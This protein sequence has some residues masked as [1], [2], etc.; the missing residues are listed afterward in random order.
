MGLAA[1]LVAGYVGKDMAAI[2]EAAFDDTGRVPREVLFAAAGSAKLAHATGLHGLQLLAVLAILCDAGRPRPRRAGTVL[3]VA[4]L[5]YAAFFGAVTET[6]YA[7]RAPYDPTAPVGVL[8]AAGVLIT[9][10]AAVLVLARTAPA[11]RAQD[12]GPDAG[13]TPLVER[14]GR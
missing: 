9:G 5:G 4:A 12:P 13:K 8:L 6:A 1:V 2:G 3:A 7:G 14:T 11:R 10:T